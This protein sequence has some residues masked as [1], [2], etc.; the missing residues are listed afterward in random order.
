[1]T[2]TTILASDQQ[3]QRQRQFLPIQARFA[4]SSTSSS[5]TSSP[6][7]SVL[8]ATPSG[9]TA[10][11]QATP[12]L[13]QTKKPGPHKT[14]LRQDRSSRIRH[15]ASASPDGQAIAFSTAESYHIDALR[16]SLYENGLLGR[17]K[18]E[19]AVNLMG[20]AIWVPVWPLPRGGDEAVREGQ[21]PPTMAATSEG[22][23]ATA[24][25]GEIFI[26]ESGAFVAWHMSEADARSF[27]EKV[28][29]SATTSVAGS[30]LASV[31][32]PSSSSS[33]NAAAVE[34]DRY[35]ERQQEAMDFIVSSG[36]TT[37]VKGDLII[38][39]SSDA[40]Q[41]APEE[42]FEP[43]GSEGSGRSPSGSVPASASAAAPVPL[44]TAI[45]PPSSSIAGAGKRSRYAT[46]ERV[47]E[48]GSSA[49]S[50]QAFLDRAMSRRTVLPRS[51][52]D[53]KARLSLSRGLARSTKLAVYEEMLDAHMDRSVPP[54]SISELA[55]GNR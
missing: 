53:L 19:D 12:T 39:G 46:A 4:S 16:S 50:G 17:G 52:D 48:H 28:L 2:T 7:A 41:R 13:K 51:E 32:K 14:Q 42:R 24:A 49:T 11:S 22:E 35:A 55:L 33:T 40:R 37:G 34:I 18:G 10:A 15:R 5:R 36:E 25:A 45:H 43:D 6:L 3:R 9:A 21:A 8:A 44:A 54:F 23:G 27:A 31:V 38:I 20:E 47:D 30:A 26:F 1:M 29:G